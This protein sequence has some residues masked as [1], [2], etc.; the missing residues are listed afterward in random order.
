MEE[1]GCGTEAAL[2]AG[3]GCGETKARQTA[4][5]LGERQRAETPAEPACSAKLKLLK[6]SPLLPIMFH[7]APPFGSVLCIMQF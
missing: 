6:A 1:R 7:T 3:G 4:A 5:L 2:D